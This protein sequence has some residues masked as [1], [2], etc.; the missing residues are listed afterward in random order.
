[1][2]TPHLEKLIL[3]GKASYNTLSIGGSQK[4]IFNVAKDRYI[5]I[6]DLT[7]FNHLDFRSIELTDAQLNDYVKTNMLT[8][9][10]I[11]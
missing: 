1:M 11:F 2:L 7:I 3:C 8:Q 6:T 10:S 9:L 5:I 4:T